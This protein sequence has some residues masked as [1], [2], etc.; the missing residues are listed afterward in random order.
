M[1]LTEKLVCSAFTRRGRLRLGE[2]VRLESEDLTGR[3]RRI[4]GIELFPPTR[5]T[6]SDT[7]LITR[8]FI[9]TRQRD[10]GNANL[11]HVYYTRV[12][13]IDTRLIERIGLKEF[14]HRVCVLKVPKGRIFTGASRELLTN[15]LFIQR[16]YVFT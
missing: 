6:M 8:S 12:R 11:P 3:T 7:R 2:L 1:I 9:A 10:D 5:A 4:N 15:W 13:F 14:V 16:N